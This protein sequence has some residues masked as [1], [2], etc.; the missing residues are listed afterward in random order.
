M[1]LSTRIRYGLRIMVQIARDCEDRPVMARELSTE[2]EV[3]PAYVDQILIPLR[4]AG[5]IVSQRGRRGGYRL[6]RQAASITVLDIFQTIEGELSLSDCISSAAACHRSTLCP[7]RH[8][9]CDLN[10]ALCST[11][12]SY[13]LADLARPEMDFGMPAAEMAGE[14]AEAY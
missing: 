2:Q 9:W 3:S 11:L 1:K 13:S 10:A 6:G 7:V 8:V 4:G 14:L 5:L 12:S